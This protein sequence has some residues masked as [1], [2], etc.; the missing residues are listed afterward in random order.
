MYLN[1]AYV[2]TC[3]S[4]FSVTINAILRS[5]QNAGFS[6]KDYLKSENYAEAEP[7]TTPNEND[8]FKPLT[9]PSTKDEDSQTDNDAPEIDSEA[10][11]DQLSKDNN[12]LDSIKSKAE[13]A[14]QQFTEQSKQASEKSN[15]LPNDVQEKMNDKTYRLRSIYADDAKAIR[16]PRFVI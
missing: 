13:Q 9:P 12:D 2:F 15:D 10:I 3:S 7:K 11:H 8:F 16:L 14:N 5:L 4:Q 1:M 6:G